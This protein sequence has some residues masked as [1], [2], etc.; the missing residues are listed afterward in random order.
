M[1]FLDADG[2]LFHHSGYVPESAKIAIEK[3][4]RNKHLI[5]LCTGRQKC[6]LYGDLLDIDFD[7]IVTGSGACVYT[8]DKHLKEVYFDNSQ[9]SFLLSFM[10]EH[11]IPC[12]FET[13]E[14]VFG[15]RQAIH[16][17][18][19]LYDIHC[20]SLPEEKRKLH[21]V[22]NLYCHVTFMDY[23][24]LMQQKINKI[25]FLESLLSYEDIE[26]ICKEEFDVVRATF[27]PFGKE[28]GEISHKEITKGNGMQVLMDF[29]QIDQ[30]DV[31][32]IGDSYNDFS[33]FEKSGFSIAMGNAPND[34]K[35]KC[36]YVTSSILKNGIYNA[37]KYLEII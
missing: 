16:S 1:I 29:Y 37:F 2:T 7:G 4:K 33:M 26:N 24:N 34:V 35:S 36:D 23:D 31:I 30:K 20:A 17:L 14:K 11:E 15:N 19:Q 32:S 5:C 8:K 3:A 6:E 27:A 10:K 12:L 21:G 13:S 18:Q 25:T 9:I 22:Y 28:S